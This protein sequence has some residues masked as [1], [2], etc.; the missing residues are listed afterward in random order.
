MDVT[1]ENLTLILDDLLVG[2]QNVEEFMANS[3][4]NDKEEVFYMFWNT[5][6]EKVQC[7]LFLCP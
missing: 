3:M 2:S 6:R 1:L 5:G 7:L 4:T